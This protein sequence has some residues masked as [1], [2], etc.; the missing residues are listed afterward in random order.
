MIA[1][2][3][4]RLRISWLIVC[5]RISSPLVT[6]DRT[7]ASGTCCPSTMTVALARYRLGR[8]IKKLSTIENGTPNAKMASHLRRLNIACATSRIEPDELS[9]CTEGSPMS[10]H[11]HDF[12]RLEVDVLLLATGGDEL[13]FVVRN[14]P[15]NPAR[16]A[17]DQQPG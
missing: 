16:V 17:P 1:S 14:A 13:F 5:N 12:V 8:N 7:K 4:D 10:G 2:N 11:Q 3:R 9:A 15:Q 6:V